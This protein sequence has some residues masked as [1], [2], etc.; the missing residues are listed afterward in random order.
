MRRVLLAGAAC[1]CFALVDQAQAQRI[2]HDPV[3]MAETIAR[4]VNEVRQ[5]ERQ[6]RQLV[7]TYEA[8]TGPR[9][10]DRVA[11]ALG[12]VSRSYMPR[13]GSVTGLLHGQ[14]GTFGQGQALLDRNRVYA[15]PERDEWAQEM[16]RR[17]T[18]TANAQALAAAG[19]ED[20]ED[21]IARLDDMRVAL[22]R[23]QDT[24]EAEGINGMIAV[25]QQNLAAHRT[26]LEQVA[27]LLA[28]EDRVDRQRGEQRVRRD[29][30]EWIGKTRGALEGW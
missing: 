9:A 18:A 11:G 6:Y 30:D 22:E 21:R 14:G 10:L 16:E 24:R 4:G 12:G 13:S 29:A 15:P 23:A 17:E 7:S 1:L 26:Q 3:H 28:A 2:V 19:L 25:E 20:A 27:L 8:I 5:L